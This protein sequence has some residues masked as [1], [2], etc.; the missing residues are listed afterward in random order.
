M[1]VTDYSFTRYLAAKQTIDDRSL[2]HGVWQSLLSHLPSG[3]LSVLEVGAGTGTM[4]ERLAGR[5]FLSRAARYTAIDADLANVAEARRRLSGVAWPTEVELEAAD[6]Y[7]FAQRERGRRVWDLI[8]AHAFLDLTDIPRL[9][10]AL[11][12]LLPPGGLFY[13]TIN[14]DGLT[15]LEPPVDPEFDERVLDLYH[16]TMDERRVA[17][18]PTGGR[19]AGRTLLTQIP[20]AAGE[21]IAAGASDWIVI[22]SQGG[23]PADEGYFLHHILKFFEESL[24]G[25]PEVEPKQLAS[26]LRRRHAQI[27]AG[28]LVLIAHQLDIC[29]RVG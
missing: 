12:A 25:R 4:L 28:E 19:H 18:R 5:G 11:F 22:P 7:D 27:D 13:F 3:R 6:V 1:N 2:N 15:A 9:L 29:G 16:Q 23:Y 24:E 21:I 26:W 10:P 14:F 20:A 8:I 17:G